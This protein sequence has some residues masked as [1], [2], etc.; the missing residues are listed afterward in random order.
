MKTGLDSALRCF[1]HR[2]PRGL[3]S[4]PGKLRRSALVSAVWA[5]ACG[6][7]A[8]AALV[9]TPGAGLVATGYLGGPFQGGAQTYTLTNAGTA[10]LIWTAGKDVAWASLSSDGGELGAGQTTNVTVFLNAVPLDFAVGSYSATVTFTAESVPTTR[11]VNLNIVAPAAASV[12]YGTVSASNQLRLLLAGESGS[13][14]EVF[15]T[16][17]VTG[18]WASVST[19]TFTG[20]MGTYD[21]SVTNARG[22]LRA[23][24]SGTN[25]P[26]L[27][28]VRV[29][30]QD[31]SQ[32]IVSGSPLGTYLL[33][34]SSDGS[35]W[36]PVS[37]NR[38]SAD[39]TFTYLSSNV[40][41]QYRVSAVQSL[42][43]KPVLD[44]VLIV[45]ESLAVGVDGNP[46]LSVSP[47]SENFRFY[48]D[49]TTT[50]LFGL[51]E[52]QL[53]TISSG[54]AN[55]VSGNSTN[56]RM[57]ISNIGANGQTYD[58][59]K[60]GTAL[61]A[62]GVSQF[63]AAP[64]TVALS[65]YAYRP[66][67]IFAVAGEGD[68]QKPDYDLR[69]RQ[70]Q[71]D[72]QNDIQRVTGYADPIPMFHSQIS[73]WTS[74]TMGS[75]STTLSPYKVLAEAEANP[76]KTILVGPRYVFPYAVTNAAFPGL[77]L[78]NEGYRWLGEYYG[79]VY[80][81]VV[82]DGQTWS[83]LKPN[84][85]TRTDAVITVTFD[86]PVP[87]LV[88]DPT[89]VTN[90]GNFGFEYWD[91]SA[92]PPAIAH[93]E[94]VGVDRVQITLTAIPT[95]ANKR[96]RYAYTGVPGNS[97]GPTTGP[98]G[99][100]RDSDPTPSLYGKTLYNWCVHFDKPVN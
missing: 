82:V 46:A 32:V 96:L 36:V 14:F 26:T 58:L 28:I 93:V 77:H 75:L 2:E 53:E 54:A 18:G 47:S 45:G 84:T 97:G 61:Y 70:W 44:H 29:V 13:T 71:S 17:T 40:D 65:L 86:V 76:T 8:L 3:G 80:R 5:L 42:T 95:A 11:N 4:E 69:V 16:T 52:G 48:R 27:S 100:L 15:Q 87:P 49:D 31:L 59:Q 73:A 20:G 55:H 38:T 68:C 83:P 1:H 66:K 12:G 22:F 67:A 64:Q 90:P 89:L 88:L 56:R 34:A 85:L 41:Q 74:P 10:S 62:L 98:R 91:D 6:G 37:T 94:P 63:A 9:V 79:K 35:T 21:F 60:K 81:K 33:E 19:G 50:N 25:A 78:S 57:L 30:G 24:S 51:Y 7:P 72:Y 99:N 43:N 92:L 39:G 23:S